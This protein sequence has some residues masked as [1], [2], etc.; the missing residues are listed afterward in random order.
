MEVK[1]IPDL[2]K[3]RFENRARCRRRFLCDFFFS[4]GL[5]CW[6]KIS[7]NR[8]QNRPQ[9]RMR[10]SMSLFDGFWTILD[11]KMSEFFVSRGWFYRTKVGI[12]AKRCPKGGLGLEMEPKWMPG[13]TRS[14]KNTS[15]ISS[16]FR[17][18]IMRKWT[19]YPLR[20]H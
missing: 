6:E 7:K 13:G 19:R 14:S 10:F 1:L 9:K 12:R 15:K 16:T 20:M 8:C 3:N 5:H 4:F 2:I 17:Q 18:R 11:S